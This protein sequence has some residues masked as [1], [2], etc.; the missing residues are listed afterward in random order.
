MKYKEL[1]FK[2]SIDEIDNTLEIDEDRIS[3]LE[4]IRRSSVKYIRDNKRHERHI[5]NI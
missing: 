5:H 3:E 1:K 4:E 2:K